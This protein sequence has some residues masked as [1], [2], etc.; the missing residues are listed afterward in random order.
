MI[1]TLIK[2]LCS[3]IISFKFRNLQSQFWLESSFWGAMGSEGHPTDSHD[4]EKR[5][6]ISEVRRKV[7]IGILWTRDKNSCKKHYL[8]CSQP[9]VSPRD[10]TEMTA[11]SS[12]IWRARAE[13]ILTK[14]MLRSWRVWGYLRERHI[15]VTFVLPT[16][17]VFFCKKKFLILKG[18]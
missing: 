6:K 18:K 10:D 3:N 1:N 13:P 5:Q 17:E 12:I 4:T 14:S 9:G 16:S 2:V 8:V 11:V 7:N 15:S